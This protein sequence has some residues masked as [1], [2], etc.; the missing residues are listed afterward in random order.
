MSALHLVVGFL[1]FQRLVELAIARRNHRYLLARGAVEFGQRHYAALVAFHAGWLLALVVAIDPA[2]AV[3]P[4]L[5][6]L[7]ALLE[8]GRVWVIASLGRHWTTRVMVVPGERR[9]RHGPYRYFSH[10]NYMVVCAEIAVVPLMFGAWD[11]AVVATALKLALLRA[12]IRVEDRALS[13]VY[14]DC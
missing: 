14:G 6:A 4:L 9:I 3:S 2:T 12:R 5:L 7:F 8:C 10:P 13:Q 11:L 1:V